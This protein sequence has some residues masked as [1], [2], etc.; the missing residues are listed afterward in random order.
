MK[1]QG[2]IAFLT[3]AGSGLG[4][5][6]A[7]LFAEEGATV[8]A[9]DIDLAGA[10]TTIKDL[11]TAA[12]TEAAKLDVTDSQA[13]DRLIGDVIARHGRLDI[14][15]NYAGIAW[16]SKDEEQR[17]NR[18][19]QTIF[20]E[21]AATGK[22]TMQFDLFAQMSDE[23]FDRVISVHILGTFYCMRAVIPTM[24]RQGQGV[25][26]NCASSGAFFSRPGTPHHYCAAKAGIIGL[27]RSAATELSARGLRVNAISPGTIATAMTD[28]IPRPI[29]E[30]MLQQVPMRRLGSPDDV[31]KTALFLASDDAAYYA[32]QSL[33][34]NG[35]LHY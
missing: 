13:V 12:L 16:G 10:Q 4:R 23:E 6:T 35:G 32:G 30:M 18:M 31:A 26:I 20:S 22:A 14:L 34:P 25:I 7:R 5:A 33:N 21:I 28:V 3:G 1:L 15:V 11:P 2:K 24:L 8:I 9:A 29:A 19:T 17:F 27:T